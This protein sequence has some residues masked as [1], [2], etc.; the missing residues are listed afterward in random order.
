MN[1][2]VK[3]FNKILANRIEWHTKKISHHDQG[4]LIPG[5]QE[6]LNIG[7]SINVLSHITVLRNH[8]IISINTEKDLTKLNTSSWLKTCDKLR[9]EKHY[10]NITKQFMESPQQTSYSMVKDW[11]LLLR[12]ETR[13]PTLISIQHGIT[14]SSQSKQARE[15]N[16]RHPNCQGRGKM[17]SIHRWQDLICRNA[18]RLCTCAHEHTRTVGINSAKSQDMKSTHK[19]QLFLYTNNEQS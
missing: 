1:T 17:I 4:G 14:S 7:Q 13:R 8:M 3:I 11:K 12:L 19:N 9:T 6:W 10:L 5:M 15:R 16:E 2:D 18:Y